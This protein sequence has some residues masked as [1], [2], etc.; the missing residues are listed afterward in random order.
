MTFAKISQA[1]H[2]APIQV[3]SN[4]DLSE[5]M[6]TSDEWIA[7][8][9]GIRKR[10]I[11]QS[12]ST[13]DLATEVARRLLEK[14]GLQA[15][16][17]DFIFVAT[18]SPDSMMP[19]TAARVQAK[20]GAS[21]AFVF[22]LTAAC[23]GFVFAL[24]TAEKYIS[25]GMYQRGIVIGSETL[26][27]VLD[28]SDRSTS[29]LFGDGAGGVLLEVSD[30]KTFLAE[31]LY[32]DGSRGNSLES[33]YL[34]LSSPYSDEVSDRKYLTMDGRAVFDFAIRD[35]TKSIQ[36]IIADASM[37]AEEIDYFLLHQANDRMLDKMSKK[38]GVS[39]EKIPANMMEYGNTSAASIPILLSECVENHRIKMDG[40]QKILLTGF[41]GGL[42]W[43]TLLVTI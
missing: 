20:I 5:R 26:S 24:S 28:W 11:S 9:T 21:K 43:G 3:I 4:Q 39:R 33:C 27:K 29:V 40:S 18:I 22:D 30:Q 35:V 10:H 36:K 25:S 8:R 42:T 15:D 6:D 16:Q 23:S 37:E 2:Y 31:N 12:E 14:S 41:G 1:A 32:T 17:L 19:S 13:S 38:L 34:G 7:S